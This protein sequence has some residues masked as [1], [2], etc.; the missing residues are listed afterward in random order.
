MSKISTQGITSVCAVG[1]Y[2]NIAIG[3]YGAIGTC[4]TCGHQGTQGPGGF[5]I[6]DWKDDLMKRYNNRFTIKTDYDA[7]DF[8]P[9]GIIIRDTNTNK[10]YNFKPSRTPFIMYDM[11]DIMNETDI[12]IQ[13]L[14]IIIRDNKINNILK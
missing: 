9:K 13:S 10:D 12:F 2:S 14:I 1:G 11:S 3:T 5:Q 7:M 8:S 4:G 6:T